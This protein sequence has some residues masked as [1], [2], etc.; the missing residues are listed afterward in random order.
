LAGERVDQ[1]AAEKACASAVRTVV[2]SAG[3]S[4]GQKVSTLDEK[5]A[6][7]WAASSAGGMACARVVSM[8]GLMVA[9]GYCLAFVMAA[10]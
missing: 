7:T 1:R 4:V 9:S 6:A 10:Y 2:S 3:R 5:K 8:A